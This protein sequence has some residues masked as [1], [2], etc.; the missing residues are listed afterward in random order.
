MAVPV[1][2]IHETQ[3]GAG[4]VARN[5]AAAIT[6][7]SLAA[8]GCPTHVLAMAEFLVAHEAAV[9]LGGFAAVLALMMAWEAAVPRRRRQLPR[10]GR[11]T[12]NLALVGV[13]ALLLRLALPVTAVGAAAVAEA[14]GWG[15]FNLVALPEAA[16]I[17]VSVVVLDLAVY[18]QHVAFH[19]V[20]LLW[21]LHRMHH[22]DV[23]IDATTGVRFHPLEILLSMLYKTAVIVALGAPPA[24]VVLFELVLNGSAMFNHGNVK[25]PAAV[26]RV[27]R[28][29]LVTP[30]M[31]RVH[32]S[33]HRDETDSNYGFNLSLWDRLFATYR[34]Q[35]RDG[36]AEMTIGL[37][38]FREARDRRLARLLVQ[39]FVG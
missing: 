34:A 12:A 9:R 7:P 30:D 39:P 17:L 21:R 37:P 14:R 4:I 10:W 35:P 24:A 19:K 36:H 26:D 2:A 27:L 32:H 11:W 23:E 15:L 18:A 25:L 33:I 29:V 16:A 28:L 38:V 31:H 3:P 22:S 1:T 5:P 6:L 20:A 13:S 8:R